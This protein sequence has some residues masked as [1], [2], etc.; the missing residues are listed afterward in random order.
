[1]VPQRPEVVRESVLSNLNL[2][3]LGGA[4]RPSVESARWAQIHCEQGG[5]KEKFRHA[6]TAGDPAEGRGL[7][8]QAD[9]R[10]GAAVGRPSRKCAASAGGRSPTT[11]LR[12]SHPPEGWGRLLAL[13]RTHPGKVAFSNGILDKASSVARGGTETELY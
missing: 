7:S 13:A 6:K 5:C 10:R 4:A 11:T 2:H 12:G 1:M 8:F 3:A 9:P